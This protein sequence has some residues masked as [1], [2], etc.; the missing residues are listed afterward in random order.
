METKYFEKLEF[1]KIKEILMS[2]AITF[3]GKKLALDLL[4]FD[5]KKD[6]TKASLQT[7]EASSLIYRKGTPPIFEIADI[8]AHLKSI[9]SASQMPAKYL[10][11][12]A[13]ILKISRNLKE[14][15]SSNEIDMSEFQ[16]LEPLFQNL[17]ANIGIENKIYSSILDENLIA[18][19]ASS[20]LFSIRK[21]IKNKEQEIRNKLNN[22][23]HQ[24]YIQEPIIT[25]RNDRFVLPV[26]N[27]YRS[28]VKGFIHDISASG[29]TVFIEPISVFELNNEINNLKVDESIEIQK[30]LQKL[31][32]LFFDL[33]KELENDANLIGIIDFI[34]AKAKYSNSI[35]ASCAVITDEKQINLIN[36][37][38][39]LLDKNTAVKNNIYLGKDFNS[40]I[41]TGPNT[42][43][44]T[45]TLKTTGL[46][47]LM[48]MSGL[49][50]PAKEGSSIFVFDNV[51]ADIG[52]EQ[53]IQESLSTFSSHMSN[54]SNILKNVSSNSLVLLDELGSGTDPLEGAS[55]AISILEELEKKECLTLS[56]T[57]YPELKHFAIT[58]PKFENACVEFDLTTLSPTYKLL[59][60]I[61]RN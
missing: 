46:L 49:H 30:I 1:N 38:H 27:E 25:V 40:L 44:K 36:A 32:A 17:Y 47:V 51:F 3:S 41:I 4:P 24:K 26:K 7:T 20:V 45:V 5:N 35:D 8:T 34:F 13:N 52:D 54:I 39:P 18:D 59:I 42:G 48:A 16:N 31:S 29:S 55:L 6:A 10:L 14:Y 60:G 58:N 15:F 33:E 37:W 50:I 9:K 61:P 43:G 19:D 23:L 11:D 2:F 12:L 28:E 22:M 21:N 56:T 57:H 53:S